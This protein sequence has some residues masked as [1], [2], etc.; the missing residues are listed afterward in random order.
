[1]D[2]S[3]ITVLSENKLL[4]KG[5]GVIV[6]PDLYKSL[7][8]E[9]KNRD[10]KNFYDQINKDYDCDVCKVKDFI[11]TVAL[12]LQICYKHSGSRMLY[13]HGFVLYAALTNY[14]K[15]NPDIE[16]INIVETGTARSF[17]A[18]CM[19]KAL[20]DS[21]RNGKIYTFDIL[22]NDVKYFWNCIKDFEGKH[23]LQELVKPWQELVDKYIVYING[24]TDKLLPNLLKEKGRIHFSFLDAQHDYIN[25]K[26]ELDSV[27]EKQEKGDIIICDDY[28][29]LNN[30]K[31]QYPGIQQAL[32]EFIKNGIYEGK[33]YFGQTDRKRRGYVV[34]KKN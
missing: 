18:I 29:F 13:L 22:K 21:N 3:H 16:E 33:V 11:D 8:D 32:N 10:Y 34:L 25:L 31:A 7:W 24:R 1:M 26:F 5:C 23:M 9:C 19:A 27:N 6:N 12:D 15:N 20:K 2:E 17:S 14:L 28:T 4:H 30:G